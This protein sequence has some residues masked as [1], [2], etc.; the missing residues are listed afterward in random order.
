MKHFTAMSTYPL[1][2]ITPTSTSH[3]RLLSPRTLRLSPLRDPLQYALPILINLQLRDHDLA[4]R[5]TQR[6]TLPIALLACDAL[7]VDDVFQTVDR[8]DFAFAAFVRAAR[9]DYFVVFANGD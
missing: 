1:N 3:S 8:D 9:D 7:N 4:R 6:Y 5:D 2:P